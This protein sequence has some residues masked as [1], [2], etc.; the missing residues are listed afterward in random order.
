MAAGRRTMGPSALAGRG[1]RCH[2]QSVGGWSVAVRPPEGPALLV[3]KGA[4]ESVLSRCST[5]PPGAEETVKRLLADGARVVAVATRARPE[6]S[7]PT[8][9]DE[10]GLALVGF[11]AF[12][13]RPKPGAARSIDALHRLGI[14]VKIITGDNGTVAAKV[15]RDLGLDV[16]GVLTGAEIE[17]LDDDH[18]AGPSRPQRYSPEYPR[19]KSRGSSRSPG[20]PE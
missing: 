18:L 11:L 16:A 4:P 17:A 14:E 19:T 6:T 9:A 8:A 15:C 1:R 2:P 3:T 13:D 12:A 7:A 20:G 5:V 10:T